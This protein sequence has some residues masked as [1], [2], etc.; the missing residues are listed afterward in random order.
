[1]SDFRDI[2]AD[3][4][5]A[6]AYHLLVSCEDYQGHLGQ[7]IRSHADLAQS[8]VLDMGCGTG[9]VA[10]LMVEHCR[11]LTV[12][13]RAAAMLTVAREQLP[14]TVRFDEAD[15]T[16]LP[17]ADAS[18]DL[19]TAGWSFGH[20]TEW[21][22]GIWQDNVR[23]AVRE[24]LRVLAPGGVAIIFETLGSGVSEPAPPNQNLQACYELFEHEFGFV[25][26][27]LVTDYR[28]VSAAEAARLTEF[29]FG[30]AMQ[31]VEQSDGSAVVPEWTGAWQVRRTRV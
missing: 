3:V 16:L 13:D 15:N 14:A 28:F 12:C 1:M 22:P 18:F 11:T 24:M 8:R 7:Y 9:R 27:P 23:A 25:C 4:S 30:V 19:V 31:S 6:R 17:Y 29:F 20:A 26:T 21:L 10:A 2:Y 5:H